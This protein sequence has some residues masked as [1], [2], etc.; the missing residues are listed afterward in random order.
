VTDY[1]LW[2]PDFPGIRTRD[3][4]RALGGLGFLIC[5]HPEVCEI[6]HERENPGEWIA[7]LI[8][9]EEVEA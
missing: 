3:V 6:Q 1:Y 7:P 8:V 2:D 5:P 4:A 9:V